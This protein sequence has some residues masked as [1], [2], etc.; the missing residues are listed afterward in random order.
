M[1]A[2]PEN[3]PE[4]ERLP[5]GRHGLT[6]DKV[7]ASQRGRM[8]DAMAQVVSE[9]GYAE[10]SVSDVVE[11]AG[12]SRR[13]FYEQFPDKETCF[14]A[15]YDMGVEVLLGRQRAAVSAVPRSDWRGRARAAIE[16]FM[17]V[18]ADEPY[19]AWA[20]HVEILGAGPA[21]LARR[22]DI[23]GLFAGMWSR[24]Y[25]VARRE[26]PSRPK[27]PDPTFRALVGG[28]DEL[29]RE[30]LRTHGARSLPQF[31]ETILQSALSLIGERS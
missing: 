16:T 26:D 28:M 4:F 31:S 29:V 30:R 3:E 25:D 5:S 21:A 23:M 22:A 10:T 11:R 18:L 13:T 20:L 15:A 27:L 7:V 1:N 24:M 9:K 14:L 2:T 19:F 8:L 6:K 12:V 17:A